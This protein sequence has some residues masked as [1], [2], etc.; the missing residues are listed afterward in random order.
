MYNHPCPYCLK[1]DANKRYCSSMRMI[2]ID[3]LDRVDVEV[4]FN[5]T[6]VFDVY[7][8]CCFDCGRIYREISGYDEHDGN[9]KVYTLNS[10]IELFGKFIDKEGAEKKLFCVHVPYERKDSLFD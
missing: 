3:Q 8:M 2:E 4:E 5:M 10:A 9:T 7:F 1:F 6:N